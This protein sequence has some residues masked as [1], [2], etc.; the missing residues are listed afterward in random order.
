M[1]LRFCKDGCKMKHGGTQQR[2]QQCYNTCSIQHTKNQANPRATTSDKV[3]QV[4]IFKSDNS[5]RS[6]SQKNTT[7]K[8]LSTLPTDSSNLFSSNLGAL[9]NL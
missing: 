6:T 3:H 5:K 4:R 7:H 1:S 8:H 2:K 9:V